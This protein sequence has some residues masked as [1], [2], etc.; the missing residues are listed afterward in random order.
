M[1]LRAL[2]DRFSVGDDLNL[3]I[4]FILLMWL[5]KTVRNT[6][7][8]V[9]FPES[10]PQFFVSAVITGLFYVVV[11][12]LLMRRSKEPFLD[13]GFTRKGLLRQIGVGVLFGVLIFVFQIFLLSPVVEAFLPADLVLGMDMRIFFAEFYYYPIFILVALFKGGFSEE[14]WRIFMLTRFEKGFGRAGLLFALFLG[15]VVFG[16]GHLYQG[17]S[18]MVEAF[19]LALLY[20][21]VYLRKRLAWE[22][23]SAHAAF[24]VISITLGY[25]IYGSV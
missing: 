10:T 23:V 2:L 14:L 11:V 3:S 5:G 8:S 22:A 25:L 4:G 6:W 13:I 12:V 18:G 7:F 9:S 21:L 17:F 24:D 1:N 20:A 19:V 15:S 16:F